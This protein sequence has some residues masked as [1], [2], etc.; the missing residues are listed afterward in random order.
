MRHV[1]T[2][3]FPTARSADLVG[4]AEAA[5]GADDN[6]GLLSYL[7]LRSYEAKRREPLCLPYRAW[8][9]CGMPP[10]TSGGVAVLQILKLLEPFDLAALKSASPQD[11]DAR[12]RSDEHTSELQSL[13]RH[14]YSALCLKKKKT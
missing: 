8:V 10:P 1:R 7:D 13:L 4:I 6:P 2:H 12:A 14:S 11:V 9:V 3:S 5:R